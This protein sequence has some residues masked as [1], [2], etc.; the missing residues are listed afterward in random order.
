MTQKNTLLTQPLYSALLTKR[1][2]VGGGIALV[3]MSLF[4]LGVKDPDPAWGKLWMIRPLIVVSLAG[5]GGAAF[6]HFTDPLRR[7]GGWIMFWTSLLNM[8]AYIIAL[9]LGSVLGLD[10][11]LWN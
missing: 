2:L 10:G 11:T 1:M 4:L 8:I 7:Q 6:Y 9:W 5:A 3:L